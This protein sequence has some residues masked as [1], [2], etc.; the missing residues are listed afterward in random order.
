MSRRTYDA[1]ARD[2]TIALVNEG[3]LL[4]TVMVAAV[5]MALWGVLIGC[6]FYPDMPGADPAALKRTLIV[7]GAL[8]GGWACVG[9]WM[10]YS[11]RRSSSLPPPQ[12]QAL[13]HRVLGWY[14]LHAAMLMATFAAGAV[15][16]GLASSSPWA[17]PSLGLLGAELVVGWA[18]LPWMLRFMSGEMKT[19]VRAAGW[20]E[21]LFA[22]LL[23]VA[24][25]GG[26]MPL[27]RGFEPQEVMLATHQ[28]LAALTVPWLLAMLASAAVHFQAARRA[29]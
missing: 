19:A 6:V 4:A 27:L 8:A 23:G 5:W 7:G 3:M 24:A 26:F 17:R 28:V 10:N 20:L 29:A 2:M 14:R 9:G 21:G 22:L 18:A 13:R 12:A 16:H 1:V 15:I 25:G 11:Y